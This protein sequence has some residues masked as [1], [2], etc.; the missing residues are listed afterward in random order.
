MQLYSPTFSED[1]KQQ[2]LA[3]HPFL[4]DFNHSNVQYG[5][6]YHLHQHTAWSEVHIGKGRFATERETKD[7]YFFR[8]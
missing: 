2:I 6:F 5:N 3:F 8:D 1:L 7:T 4:I